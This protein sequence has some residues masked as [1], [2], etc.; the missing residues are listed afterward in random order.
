MRRVK[1]L[2]GQAFHG[3][4][5]AAPTPANASQ[6]LRINGI[7][8]V[9]NCKRCAPNADSGPFTSEALLLNGLSW[10]DAED[11]HRWPAGAALRAAMHQA[12]LHT[13]KA[14]CLVFKKFMQ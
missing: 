8:L 12:Q 1:W 2:S 11:L 14:L 3:L 10:I 9:I 13:H 4:Y 7:D 5:D 6:F